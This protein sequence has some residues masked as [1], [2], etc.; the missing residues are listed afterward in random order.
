MKTENLDY[1][2]LI[3]N[4]LLDLGFDNADV[5]VYALNVLKNANENNI[6]IVDILD[7]GLTKEFI[8]EETIDAINEAHSPTSYI[9]IRKFNPEPSRF[10]KRNIHNRVGYS[11]L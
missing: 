9:T 6:P 7:K 11:K 10:I 3:K 8:T 2:G 5:E 1:I 4:Q